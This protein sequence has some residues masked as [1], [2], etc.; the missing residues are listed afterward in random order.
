MKRNLILLLALAITVCSV[1]A[2]TV[3][4]SAQYSRLQTTAQVEAKQYFAS[5][6]VDEDQTYNIA[7]SVAIGQRGLTGE[8]EVAYTVAF[9]ETLNALLRT[10]TPVRHR[11]KTYEAYYHSLYTGTPLSPP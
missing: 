4:D 10:R 5:Y 11:A 7:T 3:D 6:P 2:Q 9:M 8:S 1:Q